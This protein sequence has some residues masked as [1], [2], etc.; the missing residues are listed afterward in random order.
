MEDLYDEFLAGKRKAAYRSAD[1]QFLTLQSDSQDFQS[2]HPKRYTLTWRPFRVFLWWGR[3]SIWWRFCQICKKKG[4]QPYPILGE[5]QIVR[6]PNSGFLYQPSLPPDLLLSYNE[7]YY[8]N[9]EE[10]AVKR[11]RESKRWHHLVVVHSM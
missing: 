8:R 3:T 6:C 10:H 4:P 9:K 7:D 11:S 2:P 5:I 1:L